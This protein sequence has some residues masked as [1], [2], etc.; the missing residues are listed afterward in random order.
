LTPKIDSTLTSN[1]NSTFQPIS[2]WK[3]SDTNDE[4]DLSRQL[5]TLM[6]QDQTTRTSE[7][8]EIGTWFKEME[9]FIF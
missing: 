1:N 8:M 4:L 9:V 7:P 2:N 3:E 6:K 5:I